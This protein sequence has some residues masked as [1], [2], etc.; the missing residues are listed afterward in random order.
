[1]SLCPEEALFL[2]FDKLECVLELCNLCGICIL[3]CPVG[4]IRE[5]DAA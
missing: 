5:K 3:F 2:S 1:M 4:A